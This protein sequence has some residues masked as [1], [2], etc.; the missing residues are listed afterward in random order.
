MVKLIC[1]KG[2]LNLDNEDAV[3]LIAGWLEIPKK[4]AADYLKHMKYLPFKGTVYPSEGFTFFDTEGN[5]K[6]ASENEVFNDEDC[7]IV[8]DV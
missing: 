1:S 7:L 5:K 2:I 4:S 6:V 3:S 8:N